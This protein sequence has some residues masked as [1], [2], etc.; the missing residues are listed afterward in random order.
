MEL[1]ERYKADDELA[2]AVLEL[3]A[4]LMT[5]A[6]ELTARREGRRRARMGRLLASDSGTRFVF[7]L[8]DRVLRPFDPRIAAGQ[9]RAVGATALDGTSALDRALLRM[10]VVA[11]GVFPAPVLG[12]VG[13][14]LRQETG[15]LIYPAD[16]AS[17]LGRRL[18][19]LWRAGR[20]PNLNLL[21]EAVLGW[22]EAE[23]RTAAIENLLARGDVDCVSVKVSAI[24]P[25]LS[26]VD[27]EGSLDRLSEPM[28][29]LYRAAARSDPPKLVNLDMEEHRDLDLTVS[30]FMRLLDEPEFASLTAGLALQAYLPDTHGALDGLLAWARRRFERTG[31]PVRIRLVKG[32]NLAMERVEAELMGWP[33][34]VYPRKAETDASY[35]RLLQRLIGATAHGAV[36]VGVAS[37]NLF[38][39][40]L[41]LVWAEQAKVDIDIEML[42]GMAD[43]EAAAVAERTG[44][45]L[46]YVPIT[47]R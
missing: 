39:I 34:P 14:R 1:T 12:L 41:A 29:R 7:A 6:A 24:A 17:A 10:G 42:A 30:L 26:L 8:A 23:R 4:S 22:D 36:R 16:P 2:D 32:A 38:D 46:F 11:A 15:S 28:R 3:A 35:K 9:L 40:A 18:S 13:G 37:H 45:M 19:R 25:G 44:G 21:G 33:A 43:A 5:R 27:F 31:V 47:A 20:R